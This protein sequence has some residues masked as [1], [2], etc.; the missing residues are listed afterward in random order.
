[1]LDDHGLTRGK[2]EQEDC[3]DGRSISVTIRRD[4]CSSNELTNSYKCAGLDLDEQDDHND[5]K[6]D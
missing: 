1:M 4:R 3:I 6:L 5:Q 2:D